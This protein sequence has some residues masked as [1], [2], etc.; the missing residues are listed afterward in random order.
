M[1]FWT[2]SVR[3]RPR[4]RNRRFSLPL[5]LDLNIN[6]ARPQVIDARSRDRFYALVDEPRLDIPRGSIPESINLPYTRLLSATKN[7]K[8]EIVQ[9]II[10][11]AQGCF[12]NI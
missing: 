9:V 6:F 10:L 12:L 5:A 4:Y 8:G 11:Y 7:D 3:A 1:T 2:I